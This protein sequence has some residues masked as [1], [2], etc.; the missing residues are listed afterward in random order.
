[1]SQHVPNV[2]ISIKAGTLLQMNMVE[3]IPK[4]TT[5]PELAKILRLALEPV[6]LNLE[7]KEDRNGPLGQDS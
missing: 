4:T 7:Q 1:M 2:L 5:G 6:L 3:Y